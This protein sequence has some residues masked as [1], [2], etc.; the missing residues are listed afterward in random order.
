MQRFRI[1]FAAREDKVLHYRQARLQAELF[2]Y[3]LVHR[4][5]RTQNTRANVR[6]IGQFKQALNGAI[7]AKGSVKQWKD[8]V[9]VA[10]AAG[11]GQD[12]FRMPLALFADDIFN[13]IVLS[14]IERFLNGLGRANRNFMFARAPA[15]D[16][17][18]LDFLVSLSQNPL[19]R[20]ACGADMSVYAT[21]Q[22][23][24]FLHTAKILDK[25]RKKVYLDLFGLYCLKWRRV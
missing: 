15:I 19:S 8:D 18:E 21:E 20:A 22:T 24:R 25:I 16:E 2:G 14:R 11:L 5:S 9:D 7:L 10:I 6:K 3:R 13:H 12:R 1:E 17:G 23:Y 4:H